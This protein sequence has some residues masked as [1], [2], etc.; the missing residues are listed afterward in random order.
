MAGPNGALKCWKLT[1]TPIAEDRNWG[2]QF[3]PLLPSKCSYCFVRYDGR[4]IRDH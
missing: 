3:G 4:I 1:L 2:K